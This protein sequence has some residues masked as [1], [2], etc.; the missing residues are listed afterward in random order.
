VQHGQVAA[1]ADVGNGPTV[2]VFDPVGGGDAEPPVVGAGDDH[3]RDT[4]PVPVG[5]RHL[6]YCRG[7]IETMPPDT[8]VEFGDQVPGGGDHD[9]VQPSCSVG[10]PKR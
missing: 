5:Q 3:I 6:G 4:G 8:A 7:V 1:V 9:R 2:T 10:K